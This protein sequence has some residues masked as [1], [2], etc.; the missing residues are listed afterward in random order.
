[1]VITVIEGF[2]L[3]VYGSVVPI[4]LTDSSL[5][6]T[7]EQTG[8]IGGLVYV[9]AIIGSVAAPVL[10]DRIGRKRVL[11][12]A[13]SLF[14]G[15]AIL[16]GCSVNAL[17]LALARTVTGL[18]IG[19]SL[20]TAMTVARNSAAANRASLA[21]TVTMAGIPLGG[22]TAALVA[23]PVLPAFGW[24]PM[25]FV[26]AG[27]GLAI[28]VAVVRMA[29]PTDTPQELAG[30]L[31]SAR[32]KLAILFTGRGLVVT[33]VVA[34]CAIA[35]MVSWQGLN[36]WAA[37]AMVELGFT[38]RTA[39]LM[40]F[41]LTASAVAGSFMTAWAADRRGP[42]VVGIAT[43]G[44]TLAG[45]IGLLTLPTSLISA[46]GCVALMGIGGHST[47]NLIHAAT[48][49]IYPLSARASAL[50]WSNG[51]SFVGSFLGPVVGGTA[52]AAG[53]A[54]RLFA[55]FGVAAAVCAVSVCALYAADRRVRRATRGTA[56][57]VGPHTVAVASR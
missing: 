1:M 10:A 57:A 25:F 11:I 20:T 31:C 27:T 12:V 13:I 38:L 17:M 54:H 41:V 5:G 6:V 51:T 3:I 24:R 18:G 21:L 46:I 26:G 37:Q 55:V 34:I 23:I 42:A 45:L 47:M 40:T 44:S 29:I 15:G 14:A 39:L 35:N 50:G 19:A 53:G 2:N 22:V 32:E 48:A 56:H 4:L 28:L 30:R 43:A 36:V 8:L 7:D 16:T 52:I 33:G 9:G 49:D